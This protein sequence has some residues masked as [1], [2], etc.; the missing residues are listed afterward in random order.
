MKNVWMLWLLPIWGCQGGDKGVA[1]RSAR[2]VKSMVVERS[3][4]LSR[5]FAALSTPDDA[6]T[7]AFKMGGQVLSIPVSKGQAVARGELIAELDPRKVELEVEAGRT[8]F[9]EAS[10]QLERMRQLLAYEAISVQEFEVANTR[11]VQTRSAYESAQA[12]LKDTRIAAPFSGVIERTYVDAYEHVA[13]GQAIARLVNPS[14]QTVSFTLPEQ[15]L[16]L[17]E[18]PST[19]FEVRFDNYPGALFRAEVKNFARTSSDAS[20]FPVSLRLTED[21]RARYPISPGISCRVTMLSPD[22]IAGAMVVPL[23]A[24]YAP[25]QGGDFVWVIQSD[26]TVKEEAVVLG[27]LIGSDRV[28]ILR[29]LKGGERIVTA[30][31]YQLQTGDRVH[32]I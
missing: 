20:G 4:T 8:L 3:D 1:E 19:R 10:S 24:I 2:P 28:V 15:M 23:T 13:A 31:V 27:E 25:A 12:L 5:T 9:E 18:S 26:N 29:G 14:T 7:L 30:G 17:L 22:P 6:V 16:P 21:D 11:Y 32:V